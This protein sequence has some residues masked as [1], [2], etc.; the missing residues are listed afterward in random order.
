VRV[1][2]LVLAACASTAS[3]PPAAPSA[4][5][6]TAPPAATPT[7]PAAAAGNHV[8]ARVG[9]DRGS[10]TDIIV[11]GSDEHARYFCG[12]L[13]KDALLGLGGVTLRVMRDCS[14]D[15]LPPAPIRGVHLVETTTVDRDSFLLVDP[16]ERRQPAAG[17][18]ASPPFRGMTVHVLPFGDHLKCEAMRLRLEAEDQQGDLDGHQREMQDID[19]K[20]PQAIEAEAE[21]CGELDRIKARCTKLSG[22]RRTECLLEAGPREVEC[23]AQKRERAR[24]EERRARPPRRVDANRTC[25]AL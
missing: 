19:S 11:D 22:E 17:E 8:R 2:L 21:L 1:I 14:T 23:N 10:W 3:A 7:L 9:I 5:A 18:V 25:R 20:L 4:P 6:A 15:E 12:R 24:L 16:T 13:V